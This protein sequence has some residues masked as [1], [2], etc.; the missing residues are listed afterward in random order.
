MADKQKLHIDSPFEIMESEK[1]SKEYDTFLY[2][3]FVETPEG[4]LKGRAVVTNTGIFPYYVDGEIENRLRLPEHVFDEESLESLKGVPLTDNHPSVAVDSENIKDYQVGHLGTDV[5]ISGYYVSA[6]IIITDAATIEKVKDGK[7]ALSCGYFS[8]IVHTSGYK[9]GQ[10]YDSMQTNIRYN[11]VAIVDAGRAGEDARMYLD[12]AEEFI[13]GLK[14]KNRKEKPQEDN[15]DTKTDEKETKMAKIMV[16]NKEVD[17]SADNA[18][19]LVLSIV[20]ARDVAL[21]QVDTLQTQLDE[22]KEIAADRDTLKAELADKTVKLE[23]AEEDLKSLEDSIDGRIAEEVKAL[24]E[25]TSVAA[26]LEVS[27]DEKD[28]VIDIQKKIVI[29]QLDEKYH[30]A[31]TAEMDASPV[32]LRARYNGVLQNIDTIEDAVQDNADAVLPKAES[33]S[34]DKVPSL[35]EAKAQSDAKY[36]NR[37]INEPSE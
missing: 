11:H 3:S 18:Q 17:L 27:I 30:E 24:S 35:E 22:L 2:S 15:T 19:D 31:E 10:D 14:A 21:K 29:S 36:Y 13:C 25:V 33:D 5:R 12:N 28:T 23:K 37:E 1:K 8:D 16:D 7:I 20:D 6:D 4:F 34:K 9:W 26:R 32:Y